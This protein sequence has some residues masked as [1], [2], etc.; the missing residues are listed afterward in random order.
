MNV[1]LYFAKSDEKNI[2][3]IF[4]DCT[5]VNYE[6]PQEIYQMNTNNL[7]ISHFTITKVLVTEMDNQLCIKIFTFDNDNEFLKI[8][9]QNVRV[10]RL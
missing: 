3:L 1:D 2:E 8:L 4:E 5:V 7:N 6:M 9:C 10:K